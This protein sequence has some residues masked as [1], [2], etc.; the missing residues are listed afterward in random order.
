MKPRRR[1]Q[2]FLHKINATATIITDTTGETHCIP[3]PFCQN[4][5]STFASTGDAIA[6]RLICLRHPH[7]HRRRRI[8]PDETLGPSLR[9]PTIWYQAAIIP[10]ISNM[11]ACMS[12]QGQHAISLTSTHQAPREKISVEQQHHHFYRQDHSSQRYR[13]RDG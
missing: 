7:S 2:D 12:S 10:H 5:R 11:R 6:I 9:L 3:L 8:S 4:V 13:K 1:G